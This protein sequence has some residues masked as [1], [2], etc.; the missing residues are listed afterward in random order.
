MVTLNV[1]PL[2]KER[3]VELPAPPAGEAPLV[4]SPVL[5]ISAKV[6]LLYRSNDTHKLLVLNGPVVPAY[7]RLPPPP[8]TA[9]GPL[10]S[11]TKQNPSALALK[12]WKVNVL[13][14]PVM[15]TGVLKNALRA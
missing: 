11:I 1:S 3:P 9:V 4:N 8:P 13:V 2:W 12:S 5:L 6:L 14:K 7:P 10:A 15:F